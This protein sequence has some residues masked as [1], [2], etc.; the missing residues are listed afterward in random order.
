MVAEQ[1]RCETA[2]CAAGDTTPFAR[3]RKTKA[4]YILLFHAS[5]LFTQNHEANEAH[6]MRKT[7][8]IGM[9]VLFTSMLVFGKAAAEEP[10]IVAFGEDLIDIAQFSQWN[11]RLYIDGGEETIEVDGATNT[12][13]ISKYIEVKNPV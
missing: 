4:L 7:S 9:I 10:N 1:N 2:H 5:K 13:S 12:I 6:K 8:V 3:K 11:T